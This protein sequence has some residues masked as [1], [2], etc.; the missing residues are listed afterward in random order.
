MRMVN[1]FWVSS[2]LLL[3]TSLGN[4]SSVNSINVS[5]APDIATGC[6]QMRADVRIIENLTLGIMPSYE[7]E[8]RPDR[9]IDGSM[10]MQSGVSNTFNRVLFPWRYS[11]RGAMT[12][13]YFLELFIGGERGAYSSVSGS[14]TTVNFIDVGTWIGY[15]WVWGSGINLSAAAGFAHL[16]LY[17]RNNSRVSTESHD[18]NDYLD[19]QTRT[20]THLASGFFLGWAF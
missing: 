16:M 19:Q 12:D 9:P 20:N 1:Y 3:Q 14:S 10:K 4:A 7:C 18:V 15:Q 13:G 8:N 11:P 6:H 5:I 17:S 2:F